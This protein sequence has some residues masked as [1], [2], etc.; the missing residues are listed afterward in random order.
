MS[1]EPHLLFLIQIGLI[2]SSRWP[3]PGP[4]GL[5]RRVHEPPH[6]GRL[7]TLDTRT[8]Q[9]EWTD[10]PL[11]TRVLLEL[12][13]EARKEDTSGRYSTVHPVHPVPP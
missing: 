11:E 8:S 10:G 13:R 3:H 7:T 6:V 5:R 9:G 2:N 12:R 4:E 1:V